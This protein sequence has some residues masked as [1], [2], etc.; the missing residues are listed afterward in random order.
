MNFKTE[1]KTGQVVYFLD[2][3]RGEITKSKIMRIQLTA[4]DAGTRV[5]PRITINYVLWNPIGDSIVPERMVGA[6]A[7]MVAQ[8]LLATP[9]K[10][11][12]AEDPEGV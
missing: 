1:F 5:E 6:T 4:D 7:D 11:Y 9:A 12:F 3:G 2:Q 10:Q 8:K